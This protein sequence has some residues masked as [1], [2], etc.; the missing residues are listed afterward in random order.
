MDKAKRSLVRMWLRKAQH[1]LI[2]A[3][4]LAK[5]LPDIAIY[6]CQQCAE[7]ALKGFLILHDRDPGKTH[8]ID[9]LLKEVGTIKPELPQELKEAT[10]LSQYNQLYRYPEEATEDFNPTPGE[11]SKA[12]YAA[13]AV[14][15]K[16]CEVMPDE[17][18]TKPQPKPDIEK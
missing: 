7:K 1:D 8:N 5:D 15:D 12:F 14:Y 9:T 4:K 16:I 10:R 17:I 2:A 3:Q 11:L 13:K 6:H 18:V